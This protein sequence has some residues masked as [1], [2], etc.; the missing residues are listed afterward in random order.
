PHWFSS[1]CTAS[2][3]SSI[4]TRASSAASRSS[5]CVVS[6]PVRLSRVARAAR[7]RPMLLEGAPSDDTEPVLATGRSDVSVIFV[8]MSARHPDGR[9]VESLAWHTLDH[10]PEQ[11][12]LPSL[13][14]S[15]RLVSTPDCRAARAVSDVRYDATD[16]VMTYLFADAGGL[17]PFSALGGALGAAGWVPYALPAVETLGMWCVSTVA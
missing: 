12:R 13:R 7:L 5:Y 3:S 6:M 17:A 11:Y 14:A 4:C 1:R 16:H 2:W 10:R 8:S 15:M 9:D